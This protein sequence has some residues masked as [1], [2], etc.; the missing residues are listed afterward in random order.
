[1]TAKAQKTNAEKL[2]S[3]TDNVPPEM[4]AMPNW[5]VFRTRWNEEKG[6]K[7]KYILSPHNGH[8]A[9]STDPSTWADFETAMKYAKDTNCEGLAFALDGKCGITCIDLDKCLDAQ[10][11][12]KTKISKD[13][14]TRMQDQYTEVSTSGNGLHLF[15]KDVIVG[16]TYN[17][18]AEI[19]GDEEV[20]VYEKARFMSMTGDIFEN[21][22]ELKP[23]PSEMKTM[24]RG[25]LKEKVPNNTPAHTV[26]LTADDSEVLARISRSRRKD[27]YDRLASGQGVS[28]DKSRDDFRM[29]G[30]L[31]FFSGGNIPQTVRIM[32][33][34]GIN[35]P[36]KPDIY[37]QRTAE[38]A[39]ST[40]SQFYGEAKTS[41][42]LQKQVFPSNAREGNYNEGR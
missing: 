16:E 17:N 35:R 20:E 11:A 8:W 2:K 12:P 42:N 41:K 40:C 18:R 39:A 29:A 15:F 14:L 10:R 24:L 22:K 37:Y 7:D 28:N 5:C 36:D 21:R 34:S 4:K 23:C 3:I 33:A 32:R 27:E 25:L 13:I 26:A 1:M 38:K 6:K 31:V 9:K 30:I 19:N